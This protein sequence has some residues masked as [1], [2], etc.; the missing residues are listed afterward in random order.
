MISITEKIIFAC[1]VAFHIFWMVIAFMMGEGILFGHRYFNDV[2]R[3]F[4]GLEILL[5]LASSVLIY[6]NIRIGYVFFAIAAGSTY[7][8]SFGHRMG[9]WD[10]SYCKYLL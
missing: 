8:I 7:V 2:M 4:A 5:A 9:L 1:I 10:C 6:K 3:I